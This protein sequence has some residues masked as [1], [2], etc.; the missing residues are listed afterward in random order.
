MR[1][2]PWL[3]GILLLAACANGVGAP[4]PGS[5]GQTSS[6]GDS[7]G[8]AS[9]ASGESGLVCWR[10][11]S[12]GA[13]GGELAFSD[14]TEAAGLV[15]PLTG[16]HGHAA[17]WADVNGDDRL[18]LY[19][20][21]F[22]DRDDE[23]YQLRGAEGPAPDRLLLNGVDGFSPDAGLA[24]MFTRTSGGVGVDLDSD[25]D[26]DI[27]V[28]RNRP[29]AGA[30]PT[31]I[32]ENDSGHLTAVEDTGIDADLGGRS[33]AVLDYDLDGAPDL[34]IA[35]DRWSGGSSVLLRNTGG[36]VFEDVTS[37]AGLPG[38]VDGLGVVASDLNGDGL[39]D[40]FVAGSNRMFLATGDSSF[41]EVDS[42]AFEWEVLGPEDDVAGV[43]AAD[44]NRDG[45]MDLVVGHH[46]NST[47][48]DGA[49]VSIRLYLNRGAGDGDAPRFEDVTTAAGL[50]PLPT[51]AP[52]VELNDFNNDGWPDILTTA[53]A[54]DG[55]LPAIFLFSE[56]DGDVPIYLAP[57]G[58]GSDQYWVAGPS[59]DYDQDGR[60]DV[61]LVEW[62]P[63]LP[64]LLLRNE[65]D[66]GHW[67]EVSVS[68]E[69]G[70]GIGWLVEVFPGSVDDGSEP[71]GAREM[72]VTQGYSAGV[73]PIAHF[74]LGD[75]AEVSVRLTP[76]DGSEPILIEDVAADT[77][78][79]YPD[80]C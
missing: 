52:H 76:R 29:D 23:I 62:E 36:F 34:F 17:I 4:E 40:L 60:L 69:L 53:S 46:Y 56:L 48:E 72:T 19:V 74:G 2:Y 7:S 71:L 31:Q 35:E 77:H 57:D 1:R 67:L 5:V 18:D 37:A 13:T 68:P 38:D 8:A 44:V 11:P 22:A 39:V 80:G 12:S 24:D 6:S 20:G 75:I 54:G 26:L 64:S 51:K 32:L 79:R 65:S 50:I 55:T 78:I 25:Q 73:A 41:S 42:S 9:T 61:F 70:Y 14:Q 16:M 3:V 47:V 27:V 49:T 66:A 58:L 63:G 15:A 33:V 30:P 43:S 21:T 10:A 28:A 59:A 45:L